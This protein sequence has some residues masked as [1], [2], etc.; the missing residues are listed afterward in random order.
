MTLRGA[1]AELVILHEH[2]MM[3]EIFKGSLQKII[4]TVSECEEPHK[5]ISC[6]ERLPEEF[7][8]VLACRKNMSIEI[9]YYSPVLTTRYPK[10]FSVLKNDFTWK[11]DN[12]IAWM[13]LPEPYKGEQ[14]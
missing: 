6:S 3:P 1:I 14:E 9:M 13:P 11:Q 4:E 5:W 2:S 10:G 7:C 8:K 12:V